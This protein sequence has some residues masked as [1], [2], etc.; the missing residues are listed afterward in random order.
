MDAPCK[1]LVDRSTKV[2][3]STYNTWSQLSRLPKELSLTKFEIEIS[4]N[5]C[6]GK[7]GSYATEPRPNDYY[8]T[9]EAV[10]NTA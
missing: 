10:D 7:S 2:T 8:V 9:M 6:N 5:T 3:L 4:H 1:S